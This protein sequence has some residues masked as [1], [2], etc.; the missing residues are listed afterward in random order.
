MAAASDTAVLGRSHS[1]TAPAEHC[2][3]V[4]PSNSSAKV[5][6]LQGENGASILVRPRGVGFSNGFESLM[7]ASEVI[8][9][10]TLGVKNCLFSV[11]NLHQFI[12]FFFAH[13][14]SIVAIK[15]MKNQ[16]FSNIFLS[17]TF[18]TI[19]HISSIYSLHLGFYMWL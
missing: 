18:I 17:N 1:V 11:E 10:I 16:V 15:C 7:L 8:F 19:Y 13:I 4:R 6:E 9:F 2:T 5:L 12:T 14:P 3:G